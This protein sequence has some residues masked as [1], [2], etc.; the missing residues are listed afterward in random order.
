MKELTII[1]ELKNLLPPL[2]DAEFTGFEES[3]LKDGCLSPLVVWNDIL[4]DGHNRYDICSKHQI[5]YAI[6]NAARI[7]FIR[8]SVT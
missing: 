8:K 4:V 7:R 1:D 3:I 6:K 5:P 2:T